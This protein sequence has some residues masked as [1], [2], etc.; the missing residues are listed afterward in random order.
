MTKEFFSALKPLRPAFKWLPMTTY[1]PQIA[2]VGIQDN[3]SPGPTLDAPPTSH[4][5]SFPLSPTGHA[6]S[7]SDFHGFLSLPAPILRNSRNSRIS[8]AL[9]PHIPL[10][11]LPCNHRLPPL[12]LRTRRARFVG[13]ILLYYT[14]TTQ[15]SMTACPLWAFLLLR[16]KR[17]LRA[18]GSAQCVP[19]TPTH[20]ARTPPPPIP[21]WILDQTPHALRH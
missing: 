18:F 9:Q 19:V 7:P 15:R 8:L 1:I 17:I 12:Y 3:N 2:V 13:P 10:T 20:R 4:D 6:S 11:H 16:H 21:T 14:T 5:N